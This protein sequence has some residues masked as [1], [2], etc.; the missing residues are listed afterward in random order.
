MKLGNRLQVAGTPATVLSVF[1]PG[2][3][4]TPILFP[5]GEDVNMKQ[6]ITQVCGVLEVQ[7]IVGHG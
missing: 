1:L 6:R 4:N 2:N 7:Q 5:R 3:L